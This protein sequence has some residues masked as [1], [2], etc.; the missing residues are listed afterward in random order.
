M[1]ALK[2]G[3]IIILKRWDVLHSIPNQNFYYTFSVITGDQY[4]LK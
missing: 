3:E 2:P 1:L 4:K